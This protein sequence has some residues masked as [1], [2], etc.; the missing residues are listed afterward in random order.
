MKEELQNT[1]EWEI[2]EIQNGII[3]ADAGDFASEQELEELDE[4]WNC[5][6]E[7]NNK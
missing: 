1:A 5:H 3:E 2:N 7:Q 4:K 6:R